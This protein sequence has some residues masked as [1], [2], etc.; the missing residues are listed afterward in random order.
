MSE[1]AI[2]MILHCD[3]MIIDGAQSQKYFLYNCY[4]YEP[5]EMQTVFVGK[6]A[7]VQLTCC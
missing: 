4:C 7:D 3:L 6:A 5:A 2:E 1:R